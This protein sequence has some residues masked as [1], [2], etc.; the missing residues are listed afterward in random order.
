[1]PVTT[2][3]EKCHGHFTEV[4]GTFSENVT[5]KSKI[6]TG[7]KI[8]TDPIHPSVN[9]TFSVFFWKISVSKLKV[10]NTFLRPQ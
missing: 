5:G 3:V 2:F 1:M 4:T 10:S 8:N 9:K 6:V 7:K